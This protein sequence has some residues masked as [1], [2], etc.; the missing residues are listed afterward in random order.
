MGAIRPVK[1]EGWDIYPATVEGLQET[2]GHINFKLSK[3][4]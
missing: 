2:F 3:S 4:R 1:L